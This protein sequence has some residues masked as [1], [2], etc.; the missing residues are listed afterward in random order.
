MVDADEKGSS[1]LKSEV[2]GALNGMK[3]KKANGDET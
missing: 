2:G 3:R 1:L